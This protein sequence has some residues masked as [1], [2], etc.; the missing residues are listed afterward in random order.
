MS[1][2]VSPRSRTSESRLWTVHASS[3]WDVEWH[4]WGKIGKTETQ[5]FW[6]KNKSSME[7]EKSLTIVVSISLFT[8]EKMVRGTY[9]VTRREIESVETTWRDLILTGPHLWHRLSRNVVGGVLQARLV[10]LL[11]GVGQEMSKTN[12]SPRTDRLFF[13][14]R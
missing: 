9:P 12:D 2:V 10:R 8:R 1:E 4:K 11:R 5:N 13:L 7:G 3:V 14:R 6:T